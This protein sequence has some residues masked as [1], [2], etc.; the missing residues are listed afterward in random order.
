MYTHEDV[1]AADTDVDADAND[2]DVDNDNEDNFDDID[3]DDDAGGATDED[4]DDV[5][6]ADHG[7]R[8]TLTS[9]GLWANECPLEGQPH[10]HT[11]TCS[12]LMGHH[13]HV[14][15]CVKTLM[16]TLQ[17]TNNMI[18]GMTTRLMNEIPMMTKM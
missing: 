17:V 8:Q 4:D 16:T 10:T 3:A 18:M 9:E 1:V 14:H 6:T 7:E 15:T 13:L 12:R 2:I 11:H 5:C